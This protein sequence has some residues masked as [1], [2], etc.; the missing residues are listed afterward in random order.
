MK[1]K[2]QLEFTFNDKRYVIYTATQN[3]DMIETHGEDYA[4]WTVYV[5]GKLFRNIPIDTD[6]LID[7]IIEHIIRKE[8][9]E[10]NLALQNPDL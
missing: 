7:T 9:K 3:E 2:K 10:N 1:V 6:N 8:L 4:H 5:N